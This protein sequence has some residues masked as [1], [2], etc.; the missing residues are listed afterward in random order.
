LLVLSQEI[1]LN[2][3]EAREGSAI[4]TK[5]QDSEEYVGR[6]KRTRHFEFEE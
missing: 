6:K 5:N 3:K 1:I 4:K 2:L